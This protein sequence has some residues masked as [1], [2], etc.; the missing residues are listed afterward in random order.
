M[1]KSI[2][3]PIDLSEESS[4]RKSLPSAI[5]MARTFGTDLHVVTVVPDFGRS[6]VGGYF[7]EG[8]EAQALEK[9]SEMLKEFLGQTVPGDIACKGH[10]AHG[11]IYEEINKVADK[12]GCDLIVL[13]SHRPELKDYLLGP[14]AARVVRHAR[15]T[16]MVVRE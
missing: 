3:V 6:I 14:N 11:T 8:F 4:W 5:A 10:V 13:A 1:Y 12:L 15:Q 9:T 2:L 16:V 7:P